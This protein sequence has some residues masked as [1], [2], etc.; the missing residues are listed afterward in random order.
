MKRFAVIVFS[1]LLLQCALW[2]QTGTYYNSIDT[3]SASFVTDLHN[4]IYPHTRIT[5]D[6][7]D[8]T[9]I[10]H[11][12]ARDTTNGNK[13][14]TCVYTGYN[15]VYAPP[16]TWVTFSRE[17]TWCQSWMPSVNVSGFESRPEYSDQHHLFPV[18]QN[19]ANGRRSNHPLGKVVNVTYQFLEGKLGTDA[20]GHTV[21]EP[22]DSHKGDAARALLYMAICYNG[23]NGYNWTFNN[24]N[25]NILPNQSSPE[26]PEDVA[27]LK[28]WNQQDPPDNWETARNDYVYSIQGNRNPFVDHPEYVNVI[29]FNT[30]TKTN[31]TPPA[32]EPTNYVTSF[33]TGTITNSSIQLRWT[34][35]VAASQAPSGYLLMANKTNSFNAPTDGTSYSDDTNLADGNAVVNITYPS[36]GT[37]TFSGLASAATYYFKMYSYNG[38]GAQRNYKT[39]ALTPAASDTT[40]GTGLTP[41]GILDFGTTSDGATATTSITGFGGIRVGT[42]G[43]SFTIKNPGQTIGSGAELQGIAPTGGSVNSVGITSAEYGVATTVFTIKFEMYLSGGSSGTW[44]FFAGNGTSFGTAQSSGFTGSQVFTGIQFNFGSSSIIKTKTRSG[45]AWDSTT[46]TGTPFVQNTAYRVD[47]VGNN[48]SSMVTFGSKSVAPYTYDLF[49]NDVLVGNNLPKAQLADATNINAF[50]FYGESSIGNLAT[51]A[52]D[53]IAWYNTIDAAIPLAVGVTAALT[54]GDYHLAQNFPNP[55]NPSTT[56][57]FAVKSPQRVSLKVYNMLGQEVR[58]LYNQEAEANVVYA[59]PFDGSGLS[60]GVYYYILRTADRTE[61]KKM[62]MLK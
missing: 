6:N 9:N 51:I 27:L 12:V 25:Q 5:Y 48:S 58:T 8:E 14:V 43:G 46:I 21:Y 32:T 4:L 39:D 24:L 62:L 56:I 44:Y 52:L 41:N 20:N 31:S 34:D 59:I 60:S 11:F 2:A 61:L 53:N 55:F 1:L 49:V 26:A 35:A 19:N 37:Y 40:S 16:F 17:H 45:S 10:S 47:I 15:Y 13:V 18:H 7:F 30:L 33:T 29:D 28:Q 50:R 22:R 42:G 57:R 23:E 38:T 36:S 54:T 3:A